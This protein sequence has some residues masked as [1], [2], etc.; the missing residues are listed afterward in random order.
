MLPGEIKQAARGSAAVC[1]HP[2]LDRR[3]LSE[4]GKVSGRDARRERRRWRS[5]TDR[6][7]RRRAFQRRLL[8]AKQNKKYGNRLVG[9]FFSSTRLHTL[10]FLLILIML[11]LLFSPWFAA[12]NPTLPVSAPAS[13][14]S[15]FFLSS[16][17]LSLRHPVLHLLL[18][19]CP[20]SSPPSIPPAVHAGRVCSFS[21]RHGP[22]IILHY[23]AR[24]AP[25]HLLFSLC[26][27]LAL[28]HMVPVLI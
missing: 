10:V 22:L 28:A 26:N 19:F 9:F 27:L 5:Q 24:A 4:W 11:F 20:F 18:H 6:N 8:V 1:R 2:S 23:R 25:P 7:L 15:P 21:L 12:S 17:S 14:S 16:P 13:S 3:Q